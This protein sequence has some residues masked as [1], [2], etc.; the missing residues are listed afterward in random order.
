MTK[1]SDKKP[2]LYSS[3]TINVLLL[4]ATDKDFGAN[5]ETKY[6]LEDGNLGNVFKIGE[7]RYS[8]N[9]L[10]ERKQ[11]VLFYFPNYLRT[12]LPYGPS[13]YFLSQSVLC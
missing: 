8:T 7:L 3:T 11:Y 10:R 2:E 13:A 1:D 4:Q 5:G 9:L 6:S 12:S